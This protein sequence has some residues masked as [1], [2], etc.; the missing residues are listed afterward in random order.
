MR[1]RTGILVLNAHGRVQFSNPAAQRS[2]GRTEEDL[3]NFTFGVP[4]LQGGSEL[5]ILLPDGRIWIA[6]V[7]ASQTEWDNHPAYLV[8]IHDV[9]DR[10]AA[11]ERAH[12]LA[13]HDTLTG[14]PNRALLLD[15]LNTALSRAN[16]TGTGL[17]VLFLDLDR[18]KQIN[19]TLG[20][21]VGDLLLQA[22]ATQ[23]QGH[24]RDSD[25]VARLGGDEFVVLLEGLDSL[26]TAKAVA[27]KIRTSFDKPLLAGEREV[28]TKPSIGIAAYPDHSDDTG[29]LMRLAD[30]AMYHAKRHSVTG[31]S[32][33]TPDM[34]LETSSDLDLATPL[35]SALD[36]REFALHFQPL[37]RLSDESPIGFEALLRWQHPEKGLIPPG[38]FISTLEDTGLICRVGEWVIKEVLGQMREWQLLGMPELPV[39]INISALQLEVPEFASRLGLMLEQAAIAPQRLR[40]ELTESAL[41]K[42]LDS[43]QKT[44]LQLDALGVGLH[45][46][47]FG[48]GYSSLV[49]LDR[50]PFDTVKLDRNLVSGLPNDSHKTSLAEGIIGLSRRLGMTVLAEGVETRDQAEFLIRNQCEFAQGFLFAKPMSQE[51]TLDWLST[52]LPTAQATLR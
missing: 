3:K 41:M 44:L 26:A 7:T 30:A 5:Q 51:D 25:T 45:L 27:T 37:F 34:A 42:N 40:L 1:N 50:L 47:N 18:F 12:Y 46:D 2:L 13:Q 43:T 33:Y 16:R 22:V 39:A 14:L 4:S 19:D 24:L 48:T 9:T 11:E 52:I 32:V 21:R 23:L 49:L 17:A 31:V 28:S 38:G 6:E 20:H 36:N 10:K 29:T 8:M 15:R 35:A